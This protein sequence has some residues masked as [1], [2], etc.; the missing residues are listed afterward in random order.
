MIP[1]IDGEEDP[2]AWWRVH[3]ISY[4]QQYLQDGLQVSLYTRHKFSLRAFVLHR[5]EYCDLHSLILEAS[6]SQYAGFLSKKPVSYWEQNCWIIIAG[7]AILIVHFS[8]SGVLLLFTYI[9]G[10]IYI[11]FKLF[12]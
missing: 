3:K 6:K 8:V 5:R 9:M 1:A 7:S 11:M 12:V 4:P 2:L 10:F